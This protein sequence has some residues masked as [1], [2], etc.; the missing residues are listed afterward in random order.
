M[1]LERIINALVNLGLSRSDAEV[2]TY[3]AKKG[4]QKA[5]DL[6][7]ELSCSKK[8]IY[9]NLRNLRGFGLIDKDGTSFFALPFEEALSLLIALK[10]KSHNSS[11]IA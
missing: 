8:Q 3:L 2:Y 7:D 1:G 4:K 6:A 5:A 11:T 9:L 10:K